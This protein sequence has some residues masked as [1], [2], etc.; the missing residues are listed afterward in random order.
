MAKSIKQTWVWIIPEILN[1]QLTERTAHM[2]VRMTLTVHNCRTQHSTEQ[3]L[4]FSLLFSEQSS[5]LRCYVLEGRWADRWT[6]KTVQTGRRPETE[7]V[8]VMDWHASASHC[9]HGTRVHFCPLQRQKR[10][11]WR[12]PTILIGYRFAK[13]CQT[14][15]ISGLIQE[16]SEDQRIFQTT[17]TAGGRGKVSLPWWEAGAR[18]HCSGG[19]W[20]KE[21]LLRAAFCISN[22]L[23]KITRY[24]ILVARILK[25][26][27]QVL[28]CTY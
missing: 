24:Y 10:N 19:R 1:Q 21:A 15:K 18:R 12:C 2:C 25:A 7:W 13:L 5:L 8:D 3:F 4:W 6:R 9:V 16:N 28:L 11:Y 22:T 14:T 17:V 23:Q 26:G 20:G 27:I